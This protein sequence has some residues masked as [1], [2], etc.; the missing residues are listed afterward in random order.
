MNGNHDKAAP[1]PAAKSL[2]PMPA[3]IVPDAPE[4]SRTFARAAIAIFGAYVF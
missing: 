2:D 3:R 1:P 4:A